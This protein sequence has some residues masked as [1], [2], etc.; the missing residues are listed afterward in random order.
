MTPGK[1][2]PQRQNDK[3]TF[4]CSFH[5][6]FSENVVDKYLWCFSEKKYLFYSLEEV[7]RLRTVPRW[8]AIM[9]ILR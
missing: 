1:P 5:I 4:L 6:I 7:R 8:S 2:S 9:C 3:C